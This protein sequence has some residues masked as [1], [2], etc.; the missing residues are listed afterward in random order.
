MKKHAVRARSASR[1]GA[2]IIAMTAITTLAGCATGP[3]FKSPEAAPGDRAQLYIYRPMVLAGGGV[4][5]KV[6]INGK[7]ET[8]SLPNASWQRVLLAPGTHSVAI[9]DYFNIMPC[10]ALTVELLPGQTAYVA[11]VVKTT[12]ALARLYIS[13]SVVERGQ[14]QALNEM[15]GLGGAQ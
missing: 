13:C 3:A 15:V 2:A 14:D 9:R 11:N 5:H 6:T 4:A 10:G 7:A 12:P 8:L 1:R